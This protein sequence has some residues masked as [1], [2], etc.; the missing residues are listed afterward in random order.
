MTKSKKITA[1][2]MAS[3]TG[4][5]IIL[6]IILAKVAPEATISKVTLLLAH[7]MPII[8]FAVGVLCGHL[9]WSQKDK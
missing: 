7:K 2:I 4:A 5:I 3:V 6:D 9:F 1:I 8:P